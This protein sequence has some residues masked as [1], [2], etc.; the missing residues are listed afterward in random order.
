MVHWQSP[1][2]KV[3][4]H[5]EGKDL[6]VTRPDGRV[7]L[8]SEESEQQIQLH[9]KRAEE[10]AKRAEKEAKRAEKEVKRAEKATEQAAR[11]EEEKRRLAK[12]LKEHG[13]DPS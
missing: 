12:L 11:A 9:S 13:I 8:N 10:E 4:M 5:L 7:F 1:L 2:T 6:V 3:T